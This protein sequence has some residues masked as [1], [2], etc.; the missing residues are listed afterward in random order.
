MKLFVLI[1]AV[2]A[3][4]LATAGD[5]RLL[6]T[7]GASQL[8][9]PAG[10][11]IV[12]WAVLAGYGTRD[13]LGGT[14]FFTRVDTGDYTL[15]A[16]GLAATWNNRLELSYA[17]QELDLGTLTALLGLP[18]GSHLRQDIF[19]AKLR[20]FGDAVYTAL[21]Q[22]SLGLQYKKNK[23]F[24]IPTVAGARDDAAVDF[25]LAAGKLFIGGANGYNLWLNGVVRATRAN[26]LGLL[27][28]GGDRNNGYQTG[29]EGTVAL[30]LNE[31]TA[32]G[33]EYR[34]KPDNLSFAEEDDWSDVFIGYFPSKRLAVVAAYAELGSIGTIPDQNGL[35]LSV[36]ASF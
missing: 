6:A 33:A 32:I 5:G 13:Q 26:Q 21:P 16:Y 9:G 2:C 12:P 34:S 20:L 1:A 18:P 4:P 36:Q 23:D 3:A 35:Y 11:G 10:G 29:F 22:V 15:N 24:A 27:G 8:E 28:F 14:A 30:F 19:G 7:G 17:R 25:Y 31:A